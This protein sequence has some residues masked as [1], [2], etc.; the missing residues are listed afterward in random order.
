[1]RIP[2]RLKLAGA[3]ALP[4]VALIVVASLEVSR[5]DA[6]ADEVTQDTEL[7]AAAVGPGSLIV[8][9]QDERNY[10]GGYLVGM[11]NTLV[12][13]VGSIEEARGNTDAA[14]DD[15]EAFIAAS[16]EE[17]EAAF[18]PGLES[19]T[20]EL[21]Q[22][23]ADIDNSPF[24]RN[25]DQGNTEKSVFVAGTIDRYTA[26]VTTLIDGTSALAFDVDDADLRT[27]VEL[28]ALATTDSERT[29]DAASAILAPLQDPTLEVVRHPGRQL[30]VVADLRIEQELM[31]DRSGPVRRH[32]RV[33]RR[34]RVHTNQL[35]ASTPTTPPA[36]RTSRRSWTPATARSRPPASSA[37]VGEALV[38]HAD[39]LVDDANQQKQTTIV[40]AA[41]SSSSPSSSPSS[42]AARSPSPLRSLT[43]QAADMASDRL[44]QAV[45]QVLDTPLGDDVVVPE[46]A[47]INV[48]T[49]DE[50]AD[51]AAALNTVQRS[52]LDLAVEQAVL[53]RNIADSFVNLG[54]R[55]QNLL[56]RQLD[57]ITDL[58]RQEPTARAPRGPV[59]PRPPRHPHAPQRRVA[60]APRRRRRHPQRRLGG[61]GP[62]RRRRPRRPRRGRGLPAGRRPRPRAGARARRGR[63]RPRPRRRR[64][65]GERP[66]LQPAA[67]SRS[68]SGAAAPDDGYV[69][70]SS[71]RASA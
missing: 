2:I 66:D 71:T 62:D 52:A 6:R 45:Q 37:P 59:P 7:A 49:R 13:A 16:G 3:L 15:L 63:R 9:L 35:V 56:D 43:R 38:D 8:A 42:P 21:A 58:E 69:S 29:I 61:A 33:V 30:A 18:G 22:I 20:A 26:L 51:V 27:G 4:M 19:L 39:G 67:T 44:P 32:A 65:G 17:V 41:P 5:A 60:A 23:R 24:E 47:P 36:C 50:V 70:P 28:V 12:L 53:R 1:M 25:L 68:R 40:L 55:N 54:R 48:N 46:V 57:F 64:A 31:L 14:R 11:E 34:E 10:T